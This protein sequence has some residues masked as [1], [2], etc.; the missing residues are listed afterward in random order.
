MN[1]K[2]GRSTFTAEQITENI[3]AALPKIIE[4][5]PKKWTNVQALHIKSSSSVSLAI[6]NSLPDVRLL[7]DRKRGGGGRKKKILIST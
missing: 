5:L 3:M 7:D 4:K 1:V 6:Y 2:V